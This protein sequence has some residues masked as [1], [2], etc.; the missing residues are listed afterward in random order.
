MTNVV[1]LPG[2]RTEPLMS[3]LS[4]LGVVRTIAEQLDPNARCQWLGGQLE[5]ESAADRDQIV[6]FYLRTWE[7][8]PIVTPWNSD[9]GLLPPDLK[10]RTS[11]KHT[12]RLLEFDDPRL[13]AFQQAVQ[14][15]RAVLLE[16]RDRGW[17]DENC[18]P[19]TK[20]KPE[21]L[22]L[23]RSR[24]DDRALAWL[25]AAAVITDD[26]PAFPIVLGTGGNL[27]RLEIAPNHLRRVLHLIAHSSDDRTADLLHQ[28]LFADIDVSLDREAAAQYSPGGAG[29][30]NTSAF[31]T[32]ASLANPWT[33]VLAIEGALLLGASAA[34]RLG[35]DDEGTAAVPFTVRSTPVGYGT[36]TPG[37]AT[38]GEFWAPV[39]TSW[40]GLGSLDQLM[41]EGRAQW[42]RKQAR[43]G[44]D[45]IRAATSLGVDHG[46][47]HLVRYSIV[48]RF[49]QMTLAVPV[50][51]VRS[52]SANPAKLT[53]D[54][55][56]FLSRCRRQ[57]GNGPASLGRALTSVERAI[58]RTAHAN[59][60]Q[61][62][63]ALQ[64]CLWAMAR[65]EQVVARSSKLK[66]SIPRPVQLDEPDWVEALDDSTPEFRIAAALAAQHE[67]GA[68]S[69]EPGVFSLLSLLR[70]VSHTDGQLQWANQQ[71]PARG[72]GQTRTRGR[73]GGGL[74]HPGSRLP[75]T[76]QP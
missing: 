44:L 53:G 6:D 61:R 31:G 22:S 9:T 47:D 51:R 28:A 50:G 60:S 18:K 48:E 33:Y 15:G 70:P 38:K 3:Y 57:V 74:D 4:G 5:I 41:R 64:E 12:A 42:G 20:H 72:A 55:D 32:G 59:Q 76:R 2:C 56:G 63:A 49:G 10:Q 7:P 29:S 68:P 71:A 1:S 21:L 36:A 11:E 52:G 40:L 46:V 45:M 23:C 30:A 43:S 13:E 62:A 16:A 73:T 14:A 66:E 25:D 58:F 37:E 54:L 27:G 34:R 24:F 35:R 8:A 17:T 26:K 19:K 75:P 67:R 39:W 65:L 69:S